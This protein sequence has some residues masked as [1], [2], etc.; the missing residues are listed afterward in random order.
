MDCVMILELEEWWGVLDL[1]LG[2]GIL[3]GR[4]WDWRGIHLVN[5]N[6]LGL[7]HWIGMLEINLMLVLFQI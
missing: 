6:G 1:D 2:L 4:Y 3:G 7:G 5:L